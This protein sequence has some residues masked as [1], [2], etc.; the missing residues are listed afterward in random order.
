MDIASD[1]GLEEA[2]PHDL[3]ID[4]TTVLLHEA[5]L[6]HWAS[7]PTRLAALRCHIQVNAHARSWPRIMSG[8][9]A[10]CEGL[11][12]PLTV[13][14]KQAEG[15]RGAYECLVRTLINATI[16]IAETEE[17]VSSRE[18]ELATLSAQLAE[19]RLV[20]EHVLQ[21]ILAYHLALRKAGQVFNRAKEGVERRSRS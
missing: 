16:K 11:E 6:P 14:E 18:A 13:E 5:N 19:T 8:T 9:E 21:L 2:L 1:S 4:G 12:P 17:R 15:M 3:N 7:T 20:L 10:E